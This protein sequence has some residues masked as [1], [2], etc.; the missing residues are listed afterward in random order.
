[1][2]QLIDTHFFGL[3]ALAYTGMAV[4]LVNRIVHNVLAAFIADQHRY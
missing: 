4:W 3:A 1:M 2:L